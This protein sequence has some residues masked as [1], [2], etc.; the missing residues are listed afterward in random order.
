MALSNAERQAAWRTRHKDRLDRARQA[1]QA[2]LRGNGQTATPPPPAADMARLRQLEDEVHELRK[3][4]FKLRKMSE[5]YKLEA[6][7]WRIQQ[8]FE[9][10]KTEGERDAAARKLTRVKAT[11]QSFRGGLL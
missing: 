7:A 11:L 8:L 2:E 3:H 1:F 6:Q 9:G 4:V 5:H 10:A